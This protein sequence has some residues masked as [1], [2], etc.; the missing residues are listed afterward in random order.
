MT[1]TL[2]TRPSHRS[3]DTTL[4]YIHLAFA[5]AIGVIWLL[6]TSIVSLLPTVLSASLTSLLGLACLQIL[7]GGIGYL[8]K[9]DLESPRQLSFS[10]ALGKV[11]DFT[12]QRWPSL[13]TASWLLGTALALVVGVV[14]GI[15]YVLTNIPGI[16]GFIGSLLIVPMFCLILAIVAIGLNT[17]LL[18]CVV[19]VEGCNALT[20][21]QRL[22]KTLR[23]NPIQLM[24]GYLKIVLGFLPMAVGSLL[25][26]LAG[27]S[28]ALFFCKGGQAL[29]ALGAVGGM[30]GYG[31]GAYGMGADVPSFG[32]GW[33]DNLSIGFILF[34]WAAYV[35]TSVTSNF[36][37][38]Y[39]NASS[40]LRKH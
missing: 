35:V 29:G 13:L 9:L 15:T 33:L 27:L 3:S 21:M 40:S 2:Q 24:G 20:A 34:A 19:G 32:W 12:I 23:E 22:L 28:F 10:E 17:Y 6:G 31:M 26:T 5:L 36:A 30:G 25:V 16:G 8:V 4:S 14:F 39:Y 7:I 37:V 38:L 11:R 18:P 1:Q